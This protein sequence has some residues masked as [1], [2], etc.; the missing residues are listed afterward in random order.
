MV[1]QSGFLD[2]YYEYAR[3][4]NNVNLKVFKF[5]EAIKH[6]F[7]VAGHFF[8]FLT[9]VLSIQDMPQ[10]LLN[11]HINK[12]LDVLQYM[13][14]GHLNKLFREGKVSREEL[15]SNSELSYL[16]K[17]CIVFSQKFSQFYCLSKVKRSTQYDTLMLHERFGIEYEN[18]YPEDKVVSELNEALDKLC[19]T[20]SI[21]EMFKF[22]ERKEL[23]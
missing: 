2:V 11:V 15:I 20:E 1:T 9:S 17:N 6:E 13:W 12:S 22:L 16:N 4:F 8:D 18:C 23:V 7:G 19:E 10:L 5:E 14:R 3:K 21:S